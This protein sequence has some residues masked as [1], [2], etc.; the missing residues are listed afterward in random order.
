MIDQEDR[1]RL[2]SIQGLITL[3]ESDRL[4]ELAG[5]VPVWASIVEIGSHTGRSTLWLA[6]GARS[7]HGA[8]VTAV[9]PWPEPG[10]TAHYEDVKSDDDPFEFATGEA[11]FER[12]CVNVDAEAA[13]DMITVLRASSLDVADAWVNPIGLL[14]LDAMHGFADVKADCEA[15]LPKVTT[16]GVIALHDWFD[17]DALTNMSQVADALRDS[18]SRQEWHVLPM[19]EN[20]FVARRL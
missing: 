12:F 1:E 17:D 9:D 2:H 11:V 5:E 16:G 10:Y 4:A 20:L 6:A 7:G 8:H 19:S 13:W 15:W 14:F 3:A 18:W